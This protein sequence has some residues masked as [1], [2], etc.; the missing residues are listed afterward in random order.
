MTNL[1]PTEEQIFDYFLGKTSP[2]VSRLISAYL[3]AHPEKEHELREWS[4]LEAG[5]KNIPLTE[6]KEIVLD[7]VR[8]MARKQATAPAANWLVQLKAAFTTRQLALSFVLVLVLAVSFAIKSV[9]PDTTGGTLATNTTKNEN[10]LLAADRSEQTESITATTTNELASTDP[11]AAIDQYT[12][13]VALYQ[14]GNFSEASEGFSQIA[15]QWPTFSKK[16]ELY[17]Y[18]VASLNKLG[19]Y[20]LAEKKQQVLEEIVGR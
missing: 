17:T 10:T 13:A 4:E 9:P 19:L 14:S 18:W 11:T 15:T 12:K 20:D 7:R 8:N 5:F 2:E 6:P 16:A 3:K 1:I